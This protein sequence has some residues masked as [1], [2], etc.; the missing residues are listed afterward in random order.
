MPFVYAR[1]SCSVGYAGTVYELDEGQ[2]WDTTHALV[3][4]RPG[5]FTTSRT[6]DQF[7]NVKDYL[8]KGDGVTDDTAA[9]QAADAAAAV[10]AGIVFF[11]PGTYMVSYELVPSSY[12]TWRGSGKYTSILKRTAANSAFAML[13]CSGITGI[14]IEKLGF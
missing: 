1:Q 14:R 11:P 12:V 13:R 8:A 5:F 9:I 4:A 7:F 6:G 10:V 3:V 2:P